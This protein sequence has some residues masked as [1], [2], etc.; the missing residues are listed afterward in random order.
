[1]NINLLN[2]VT[3]SQLRTDLPE[4]RPGQTVRVDVRIREGEKTRIQA[5]EGV[6]IAMN[7]SGI[8][9]SIIVRKVSYGVGV[10]RTFPIHSPIVENITVL[11]VGKV[12]RAK[13]FYLRSRSG[14]RARL[15]E[16]RR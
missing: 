7:G 12:R 16:V 2:E 6:I 14:R 8:S 10:E 3:Q 5:Y 4:L 15:K 11:R 1:M 13:L 9:K